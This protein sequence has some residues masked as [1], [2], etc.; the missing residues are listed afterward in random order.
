MRFNA[1]M[2]NDELQSADS[3]VQNIYFLVDEEW[4]ASRRSTLWSCHCL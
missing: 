1:I 2:T 4:D 3:V